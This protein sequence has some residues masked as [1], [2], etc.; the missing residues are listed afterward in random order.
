MSKTDI[1]PIEYRDFW[2]IV[3]EDKVELS[4]RELRDLLSMNYMYSCSEA[5][6]YIR[7]IAEN[8]YYKHR[9]E[10][11]AYKFN[12][13]ESSFVKIMFECELCSISKKCKDYVP[14]KYF[15]SLKDAIIAFNAA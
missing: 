3:F 4:I 12:R 9:S 13:S 11:D 15:L 1:T 8:L 7:L 10:C 6:A 5:Q 2:K 14:K